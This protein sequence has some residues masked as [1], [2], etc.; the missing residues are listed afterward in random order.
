MSLEEL[1]K[2]IDAIDTDL[3]RLLNERA[4]VV[5]AVGKLKKREGLEIYAPEREEKLL[6]SLVKKSEG[7]LPEK[8]IRAI[9][10]EIMSA[11]LALEEDLK[12]AYLGPAGTWTHQ[13]AL[14]KFGQSVTCL[15][16]PSFADIFEQVSRGLVDYGV[17]PIENSTEGAVTHTL[18]L[19]AESPLKIYGQVMLPIENNLMAK[20]G[21]KEIKRIY[22]HP[23]VIAQCRSWLGRNFRKIP[24]VEISSTAAAAELASKEKGAAVLGGGLLAE[25]YG[26]DILEGAIQDIAT[27]T[28]RFLV[29]SHKTCPPTGD[30]RTSVMFSV[31]D[32]PGS[33]HKALEPFEKFSINMSK[34]ES[35][36]SKRR[37]WEYFFFVDVA[38]HCEDDSLKKVIDQLEQ[39]CSF[40]KVLGSYPA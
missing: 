14:R 35:R 19:F 16:Q 17:V 18:D 28:T 25:L 12:I 29:I 31:R 15:P 38:G 2:Q 4:D 32:E 30:D 13:A 3:L 23:Q 22:S 40:V 8:S 20:C 11:A 27:N 10:R 24:A 7:R 37:A 21:R 39:H 9:Y 33:L 6:K 36:P 1:R 26:L 34:I 5:H